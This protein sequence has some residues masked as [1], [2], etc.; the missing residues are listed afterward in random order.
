VETIAQL[1]EAWLQ[2][3]PDFP[4]EHKFLDETFQYTYVAEIKAG[5]QFRIFAGLG[6][7][8]A[9]LGLFGLASFLTEQKKME[10]GVRKVMGST[11]SGI[12]WQLSKQFVLWVLIANAIAWPLAWYFMKIW[13]NGFEY[14][15][16][17]NPLIFIFAGVVSLAIAL[18]TISLKTWRAA[19][20]NPINAL[21]YE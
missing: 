9:C 7:F 17:T 2:V 13:L 10:I 18:V 14:R 21:K 20:S 1:E 6:I 12:I 19:N 4:F 15:T 8:I 16:S 3:C 5:L 11:S